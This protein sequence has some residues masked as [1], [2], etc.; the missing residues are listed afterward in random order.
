VSTL[1]PV[2]AEDRGDTN[3][4]PTDVAHEP[5]GRLPRVVSSLESQNFRWLMAS[6]VAGSTANW[7]EIVVRSWIVYDMSGSAIAMGVV[8]AAKQ[9]PMLFVGLIGGVLADRMDR[10][11]LIVG[12][13]VASALI[14]TILGI[15][16]LTGHIAV[17][18]FAVASVFEGIVGA[19]QQPARQA[20][21]PSVVAREHLMNAVALSGSV[22]TISKLGGP[23]LAGAATAIAGPAAALFVEAT[24]YGT[25][26]GAMARVHL[27]AIDPA[28]LAQNP[29]WKKQPR[30]GLG[31]IEGFR[32]YSYLR[33]N[34]VVGWLAIL[35]LVPILFT[36]AQQTLAPIFAKDILGI[37]PGGLGLLFGAPAIG[38][39]FATVYI[40]AAD[41]V[42]HKGLV[43]LAAV[44]LLG[45]SAIVFGLSGWLWLSLGAL[46]MHG[47]AQ[48]AY[49]ALSQTLLQVHT[50]DE[51]RG[52]V[53]AIWAAD[54]G[55]H[56][57]STMAIAF[58]ADVWG[59]STAVVASGI[60]C[61]LVA[62]LVG[63]A[64]RTIRELD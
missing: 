28:T 48:M 37:G 36:F 60:G 61:V 9:V 18:Q 54:R 57:I 29:R 7:T 34:T 23:A 6:I 62:L 50:E 63:A 31:L 33:R 25:G 58:A 43:T 35:S 12:S 41:E 2:T 13:Q 16:V 39:V 14:A 30:R 59:P 27:Q 44:V 10:K 53:M 8:Q 1:G 17:W 56:P 42:P 5:P 4:P 51:Y 38:A 26:A 24:L 20:L 47:F 15:L 19:I 64:S 22:W 52:R 40:A 3:R 49:R 55:L 21:I 32:G 46:A 45:I 11:T